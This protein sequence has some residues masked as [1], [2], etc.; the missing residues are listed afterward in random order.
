MRGAGEGAGMGDKR[1]SSLL[2]LLR[3]RAAGPK[4]EKKKEPAAATAFERSA[5]L[6][7]YLGT[8]SEA[9]HFGV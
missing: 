4:E 8:E 7:E 2:S 9:G 5:H 3:G 1:R 6:E